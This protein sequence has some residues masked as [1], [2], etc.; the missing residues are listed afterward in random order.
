MLLNPDN[1]S[2]IDF[3]YKQNYPRDTFSSHSCIEKI[4]LHLKGDEPYRFVT[5]SSRGPQDIFYKVTKIT[6][7]EEIPLSKNLKLSEVA[8][9][10]MI[11]YIHR[12]TFGVTF[13]YVM[14]GRKITIYIVD[15]HDKL[16]DFKIYVIQM[17]K[18]IRML[19]HFSH[20][21]CTKSSSFT[22]YIYFTPFSKI[23]PLKSLSIDADSINTGVNIKDRLCS[24]N[25]HLNEIIIYREEDWFKVFIHESIH[26]FR[27]DFQSN[28]KSEI[29]KIYKVK[30]EVNLFESYTE[31]WAE[32]INIMV[33]AILLEKHG[34][35]ANVIK[36]MT[37]MIHIEILFGFFQ[38]V[39]LLRHMGL[40]Y[41]E[42]IEGGKFS[43]KYTEKTNVLSY[44][45]IK[46]IF[47]NNFNS[48]LLF[49]EKY[50]H[51]ILDFNEENLPFLF[52]FIKN[53]YTDSSFIKKIEHFEKINTVD[54]TLMKTTKMTLFELK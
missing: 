13:E 4:Y 1:N 24:P 44:F 34:K 6:K 2:M 40:T 9:Q 10:K 30:S 26:S 35:F 43:L 48:F 52:E 21:S 32:F 51:N 41:A 29:M 46:L 39:K 12:M 22:I 15:S 20:K 53:R 19:T 18:V 42:L 37:L 8:S 11:N 33:C 31:F 28:G 17:L 50:G 3:F 38:V 7:S 47:M 45:I 14:D 49:C 36:I 25:E 27:L 5:T 16:N 23:L 54:K